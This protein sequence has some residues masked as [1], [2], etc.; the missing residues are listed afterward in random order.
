MKRAKK[1]FMWGD[2]T[3]DEY[4]LELTKLR[5]RLAEMRPPQHH[6]VFA[7][8]DLLQNFRI[9]WQNAT[10]WTTN[11]SRALSMAEKLDAG[12]IWTNSPHYLKWN[13]P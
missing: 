13:V 10:L 12:I 7:A 4:R 8:G 1:L 6:Q 11:L 2:I 3:E 9:L 5:A